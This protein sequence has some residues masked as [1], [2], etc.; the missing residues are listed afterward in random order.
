VGVLLFTQIIKLDKQT[1]PSHVKFGKDFDVSS[2]ILKGS[3]SE[4]GMFL[5]EE[6][7]I[8]S[9]LAE[10][11]SV[12]GIAVCLLRN[13]SFAILYFDSTGTSYLKYL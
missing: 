11:A 10:G 12:V 8:S 13:T 1:T 2:K 6:G 4:A 3:C 7:V 5:P 9:L